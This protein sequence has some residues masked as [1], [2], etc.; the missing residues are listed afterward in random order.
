MFAQTKIIAGIG[1]WNKPVLLNNPWV[2]EVLSINAPWHNKQVCQSPHNSLRG[3][4]NSLRYIFTSDEARF[5]KRRKCGIGIDVLGSPE[6]ALLM[7]RAGVPWRLGVKGYAGGHS[8]CQQNVI[9]D[10]QT[11]VG[12]AALKFAELLGATRLPESRPQ[13][14][15]VESEKAQARKTWNALERHGKTRSTCI[16]IAPG[17]GLT[18]KS[19][20]QEN[21]RELARK[22]AF[23]PNVK[24]LVVGG[25]SDYELG[26]FVK[27]GSD[28][29][30]NM[31][32]KTS[33]RETFALIWAAQGV[34]C[35]SSMVL[36]AAAAFD[37]PTVVLLGK[38]FASAQKHKQLWGYGA[39]DLHLGRETV[40]DPI[41]APDE[42]WPILKAHLGLG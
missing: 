33:L 6:G 34:V 26:E 40:H 24:I 29:V 38:T 15:L 17:G 25:E 31:C 11:Q 39:N 36:H 14:F 42:V 1:S 5:L 19:W 23:R 12:R 22:L 28:L 2:D 37:K 13:L 9:F 7:M 8:A 18:E 16:L 10:E 41:T 21:Y 3:L 35:N 27:G 30:A 20:P 32:G 4:L